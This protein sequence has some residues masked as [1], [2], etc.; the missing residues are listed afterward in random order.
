MRQDAVRGGLPKSEKDDAALDLSDAVLEGG[1]SQSELEPLIKD[2]RAVRR[3]FSA[4]L[5]PHPHQG[6]VGSRLRGSY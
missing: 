4:S 3:G 1:H 5:R 6:G 2:R